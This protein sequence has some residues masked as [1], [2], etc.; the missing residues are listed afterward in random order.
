M[1]YAGAVAAGVVFFMAGGVLF[2]Q[3]RGLFFHGMEEML[4]DFEVMYVR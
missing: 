3:C 2:F 1:E 4:R